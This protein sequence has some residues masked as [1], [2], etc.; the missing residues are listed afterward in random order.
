MT[1]TY[2]AAEG[3]G[4][5]ND[6]SVEGECLDIPEFQR[7]VLVLHHHVVPVAGIAQS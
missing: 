6:F 7:S 4:V 5:G 3:G 1:P 2:D